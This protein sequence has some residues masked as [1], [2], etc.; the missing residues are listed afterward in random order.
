MKADCLT[1]RRVFM[2]PFES[3]GNFGRARNNA[4][5]LIMELHAEREEV[6][7]KKRVVEERLTMYSRQI[8]DCSQGG[9]PKTAGK[10]VYAWL[11]GAAV[12]LIFGLLFSVSGISLCGSC[13]R[14]GL[15]TFLLIIGV[16]LAVRA[17]SEYIHED[18]DRKNN[19][20]RLE[21]YQKEVQHLNEQLYKLNLRE[22]EIEASIQ[23][24]QRFM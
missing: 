17:W 5:S 6:R 21:H 16:I 4:G 24:A 12:S 20:G 1:V 7:S 8:A 2:S 18:R 15:S 11:S 3:G 14:M 22:A 10:S 23:S 19:A 9:K 13:G